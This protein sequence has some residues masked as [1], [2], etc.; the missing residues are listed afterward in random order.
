MAARAPGRL[1]WS[2]LNGAKLSRIFEPI[3]GFGQ[4]QVVWPL[5]LLLSCRSC[6]ANRAGELPHCL[7]GIPIGPGGLPAQFRNPKWGKYED[8]R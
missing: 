2:A 1:K 6:L 4:S 3:P 7:G 5:V 8:I